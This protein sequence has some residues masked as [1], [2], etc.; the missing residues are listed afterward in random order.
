M[1]CFRCNASV[2][3]GP[4]HR[5]NED[6][7]PPIWACERHRFRWTP[8]RVWLYQKAKEERAASRELWM[9]QEVK[10]FCQTVKIVDEGL[11]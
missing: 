3:Q 2:D 6:G 5:I 7:A 1:R 10:A 8:F 4:L 11:P 9:S